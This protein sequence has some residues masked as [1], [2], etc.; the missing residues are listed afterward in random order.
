MRNIC[1]IR[2]GKVKQVF[3]DDP[4]RLEHFAQVWDRHGFNVYDCV[5][6]L[7]DGAQERC[8][9]TV[10]SLDIIHV[11]VDL[12]DLETPRD[13]VLARLKALPLPIEIRDSGG[14][15]HV[16]LHLKEPAEAGTD[17]FDRVTVLRK[18]LTYLLAG[19]PA[20]DHAAALLRR[21]GTSNHKYGPPRPCKVIYP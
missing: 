20:P 3:S 8:L 16:I 10:A 17:E 4:S 11:D 14:G 7:V 13:Q 19:D 5:A 9:E 6:E 15:F 1:A 2:D 12:R 21:P 18:R